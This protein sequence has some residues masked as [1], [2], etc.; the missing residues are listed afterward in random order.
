MSGTS[1]P[2][3]IGA[4]TGLSV[5][6]SFVLSNRK[7]TFAFVLWEDLGIPGKIIFTL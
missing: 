3:F 7:G 6:L 5:S 2:A 1:S 4:H